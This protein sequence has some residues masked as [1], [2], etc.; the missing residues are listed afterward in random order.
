MHFIVT[1]NCLPP[2]DQTAAGE[3]TVDKIKRESIIC[4]TE[5]EDSPFRSSGREQE[6]EFASRKINPE[7][8]T[9]NWLKLD[10]AS[11]SASW[12]WITTL[13]FGALKCPT[14]RPFNTKN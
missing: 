11:F 13:L 14:S 12:K 1:G 10:C 3:E 9:R 2:A 4:G 8:S 7:Y 6:S 5:R